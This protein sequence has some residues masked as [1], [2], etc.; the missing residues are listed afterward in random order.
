MAPGL[1]MVPDKCFLYF[2]VV[3]CGGFRWNSSWNET[4]THRES[5]IGSSE[6]LKFVTKLFC[7]SYVKQFFFG[8][9]PTFKKIKMKNM[10]K[11]FFKDP[12]SILE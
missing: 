5:F 8:G 11:T 3:V 10:L 7:F 12:M 6:I 4:G 2:L 1:S 9:V